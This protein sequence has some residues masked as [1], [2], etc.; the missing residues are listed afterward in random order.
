MSLA[1]K[2]REELKRR[3][4]NA[5]KTAAQGAQQEEKMG[6]LG[7]FHLEEVEKVA[8]GLGTDPVKGLT[9]QKVAE[10]K[11]APGWKPNELTPPAKTPWYWKF[12]EHLTGLFSL[13]L[14]TAAALCFLAVLIDPTQVE[15][16]YLGIV[17]AVVVFMTGCFSYYQD[18]KADA[19]MEGFANMM[20][21]EVL[22]I[23]DAATVPVK[24]PARDLVVGDL[25][26]LKAGDKIPAD[27]RVVSGFQIEVDNS[28]LTGENLAQKRNHQVSSFQRALEATNILYYGTSQ[29][30]GSGTAFV[31]RTGDQTA[32]GRIASL[33]RDTEQVETPIAIE[34]HHFIKIVTYV[35]VFLGATFV[36]IG[37][38]KKIH[39]VDNLV[40][41]IGIIVANVPEGL[42][43]TVTVSLTLT[44]K[45]MH[46]KQV[47]VKNLEA[48]ETLG[49][50][51][52][53]ASDKTGTLTCNRMTVV[54]VF[55]DQNLHIC[56]AGGLDARD[57]TFQTLKTIMTLCNCYLC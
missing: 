22:V 27:C 37:F 56:H 25:I 53:I 10:I 39:P 46:Q 15:Y 35:A 16:L 24:I 30:N 44:S 2:R 42:L 9:S 49:S 20:P 48:V 57:E 19:V 54:N 55:Y 28:S 12:F 47:L 32:M 52:V 8:Q 3:S 43:A 38:V 36:I 1:E 45:R 51:T 34:I 21:P 33:V 17:L 13:L 50:T 7:S 40:F 11:A 41:G 23:R 5:V 18:A 6:D 4:D 26:Q 31:V 29:T 14:W